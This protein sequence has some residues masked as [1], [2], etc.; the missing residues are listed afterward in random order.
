MSS[1]T[2][3]EML[4][5]SGVKDLYLEPPPQKATVPAQNAKESRGLSELKKIT[6]ACTQCSE[7]AR[8]RKS[9][10]FGSGNAHADLLFV[11]EAPGADEDIQGL[12]FVGRA[13]QLLTKMIEAIQLT[14]DEVYI[15]NVLKCRPPGNRPPKL[16]EIEN[17]EPYLKQQIALMQPKLICALG[18]FAAQTLL[19]TTRSISALRGRTHQYEGIP[20]ICTFHPSYLLR[21][22]S[23]K[24][25]AWEDL[26]KV[27]SILNE[28]TGKV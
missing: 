7:L 4:K 27:R 12:P 8:T 5:A 13:G 15:A 23:E 19:K 24:K 28:L 6:L 16:Q 10:V 2:F 9:V 21:S 14:R 22:P 1:K 25:R 11:G 18:T 20:V 3:L 17:C 26:K